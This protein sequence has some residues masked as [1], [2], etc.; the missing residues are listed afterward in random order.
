MNNTWQFI[1]EWHRRLGI[2]AAF[3]VILL[4]VTGIVLNHTDSLNLNKI[5]IQSEILLDWYDIRP[6]KKPLGYPFE[7]H[8]ISQVGERVYFDGVEIANDIETLK[9]VVLINDTVYIALDYELHLLTITGQH[10]EIITSAEGVPSGMQSL[11]VTPDNRLVIKAAHGNYLPDLDK[12]HWHEEDYTDAQWS[13]PHPLPEDLLNQLLKLYRGKGLSMERLL[14]DVHSGRI[15]GS[16]G[17]YL[18]DIAAILFLLLAIS[19][20]WM[21]L[22]K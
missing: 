19:G 12:L 13:M 1:H 16:F 18:I 2:T 7:S 9:G 4:A 6:E 3:F 15:I 22:K 21:W 11:G 20:M 5:F 8:W 10:I 17:V 14:L